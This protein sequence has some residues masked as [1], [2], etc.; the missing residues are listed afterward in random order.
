MVRGGLIFLKKILSDFNSIIF[1]G[2][3]LQYIICMNRFGKIPTLLRGLHPPLIPP[4]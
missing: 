4:L 1:H 2:K 3:R